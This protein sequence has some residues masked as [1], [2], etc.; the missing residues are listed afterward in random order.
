MTS[1]YQYIPLHHGR[2][3]VLELSPGPFDS[4]IHC[5]LK[6]TSLRISRRKFDAVSYTWAGQTRRNTILCGPSHD[7]LQVTDNCYNI[8]LHLRDTATPRIVW[9]DAICLN[10]ND[11]SEKSSQVR[12]MGDIYAAAR[13]TIIFLGEQT[14]DSQILFQHIL[15][16]SSQQSRQNIEYSPLQ[17]AS[18]I[19]ATKLTELLFRRAWFCRIW[20]VQELARSSNPIF[21]CGRHAVPYTALHDFLYS[22]PYNIRLIKDFP[23]ALHIKDDNLQEDLTIC[24]TE[25]LDRILALTPLVETQQS[26]LESLVN[27][28]QTYQELFYHF[29]IFALDGGCGLAFLTM[30]RRPH[31]IYGLPSWV[32]DWAEIRSKTYNLILLPLYYMTYI[33]WELRDEVDL[34]AH[35]PDFASHRLLLWG[36]PYGH[37]D[38]Q[39]P[40]IRIRQ[41]NTKDKIQDV[42]ALADR[43]ESIRRGTDIDVPDWPAPI[44]KAIQCISSKNISPLLRS[45]I[46]EL[47][48]QTIDEA[49][50]SNV[51]TAC[52]G[53][54]IF[55]TSDGKLGL[56]P[57]AA[58]RGDLVCIVLGAMEPCILR[59]AKNDWILDSK[60][61][62]VWCWMHEYLMCESRELHEFSIC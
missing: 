45:R 46:A 3:R 17:P 39:G 4:P 27:Y 20:V 61:P 6:L 14:D 9:I 62:G 34:I 44:K 52:D 31:N 50:S 19:D 29:T 7:Q 48:S 38:E 51:A 55:I 24:S 37:I 5:H 41:E 12:I 42:T 49:A 22:G 28:D 26:G 36:Y 56:C 2:I 54:K 23:P 43:I 11:M 60:G 25:R 32:P 8:L 53:G 30:I 57:E 1:E 21:M 58:Q 35:G 40:T 33:Y 47:N 13:Q 15:A 18:T 59:K 10:Q 16:R